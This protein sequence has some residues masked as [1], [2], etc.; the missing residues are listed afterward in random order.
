MFGERIEPLLE[1]EQPR[2]CGY[3]KRRDRGPHFELLTSV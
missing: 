3:T 1:Y 2:I